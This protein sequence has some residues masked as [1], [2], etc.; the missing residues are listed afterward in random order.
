MKVRE[1]LA[2]F[3][4]INYGS[5]LFI[6]LYH[7]RL[8]TIRREPRVSQTCCGLLSRNFEYELDILERM[9]S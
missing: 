7:H 5:I 8:A 9:E 4:A 3:C 2:S 6:Q 1:T